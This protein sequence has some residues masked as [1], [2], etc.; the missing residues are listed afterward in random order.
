M[1]VKGEETYE[2]VSVVEAGT[3]TDVK[4]STPAVETVSEVPNAQIQSREFSFSSALSTA[5]AA[6]LAE[7]GVPAPAEKEEPAKVAETQQA[8]ATTV[9]GLMA[10]QKN[11]DDIWLCKECGWRYP[12]AK[13]SAKVRKNHKKKCPKK[14]GSAKGTDGGSSDGT[15]SD[16]DSKLKGG[17]CFP[18]L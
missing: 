14:G 13:P 18:C 9:G 12:N 1:A 17:K 3:G 5:D 4:D 6:P 16:D 2:V 8:P 15:S 7:M 11:E 10:H